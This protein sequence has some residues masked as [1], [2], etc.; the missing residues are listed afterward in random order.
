MFLPDTS[1]L[2]GKVDGVIII[3]ELG[4]TRKNAIEKI[5]DQ[6][7]R[8]GAKLFGVVLNR[9]AKQDT[10]YGKYHSYAYGSSETKKRTWFKKNSR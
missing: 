7:D 10:Y 5:N 6:I 1:V 3:A 4:R 9:T 8:S 2:L